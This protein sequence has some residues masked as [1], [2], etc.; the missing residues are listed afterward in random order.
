VR[1]L[2]VA[3]AITC[4]VLSAT[5]ALADGLS[6]GEIDRL[7]RGETVAR[8]QTLARGHRRYV[9]GV[10]YSI[11]DT[12]ADRLADVLASVDVWRRLL[13]RTRSARPVGSVSGDTLIELTQGSALFHARYTV[14]VRRDEREVRFWMEP[15]RPHD[16]EDAW[17]F[18]RA[19]PLADGRTLVTFGALIDMGPGLLRDLFESRVRDLALSVPDRVRGLVLE[20]NAIGARAAR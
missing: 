10:A 20:R 5:S 1:T 7:M 4:V 11:V 18:L 6:A 12:T 16:I 3:A 14:R 2:L 17:G 13:P 19:E 8:P 15:R 9:G